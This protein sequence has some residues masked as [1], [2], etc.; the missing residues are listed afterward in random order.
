MG[1]VRVHVLAIKYW[2]AGDRWKFA[3][4]YAKA[5]VEGFKRCGK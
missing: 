5:I 2:L 3:K 4:A 1:W